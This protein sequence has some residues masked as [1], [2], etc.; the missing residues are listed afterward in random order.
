MERWRPRRR[1]P[2]RLYWV[3]TIEGGGARTNAFFL[4]PSE[5]SK[6]SDLNKHVT[7]TGVQTMYSELGKWILYVVAILFTE[8]KIVRIA[9]THPVSDT[10]TVE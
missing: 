2:V 4:A 7:V 5:G 6:S 8:K 1:G 9:F 10:A 3:R